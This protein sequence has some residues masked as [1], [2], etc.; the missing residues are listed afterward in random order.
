MRRS[1][2]LNR[3]KSATKKIRSMQAYTLQCILLVS[4]CIELRTSS[5]ITTVKKR[6]AK[7]RWR[8]QT[9]LCIWQTVHVVQ[10]SHQQVWLQSTHEANSLPSRSAGRLSHIL[11]GSVPGRKI[12]I[13]SNECTH[14]C[15]ALKQI[16]AFHMQVLYMLHALRPV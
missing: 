16:R 10:K 5:S 12:S 14:V 15:Y 3:L 6:H 13:I 7:A 11:S 2:K 8:Q 9:L 4:S 1:G